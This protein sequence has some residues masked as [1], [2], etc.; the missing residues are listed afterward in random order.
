MSAVNWI[1]HNRYKCRE[2]EHSALKITLNDYFLF[3]FGLGCTEMLVDTSKFTIGRHRPNFIASCEPKVE[4]YDAK[5]Q[6][7]VAIVRITMIFI[8]NFLVTSLC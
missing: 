3:F 5:S 8:K 6:V 4:V 2:Q 7:R 1:N